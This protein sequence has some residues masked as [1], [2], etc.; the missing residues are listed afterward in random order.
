MFFI[1]TD[2]SHLTA[3]NTFG[4]LFWFK[5]SLSVERE[6]SS[7]FWVSCRVFMN[8][9]KR[10]MR[11]HFQG[12]VWTKTFGQINLLYND[13]IPLGK[14]CVWPDILIFSCLVN[15]VNQK[16]ARTRIHK[17]M[18][19]IVILGIV[20]VLPYSGQITQIHSK[21]NDKCC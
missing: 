7:L 16:I 8:K 1:L 11:G 13:V 12:F 18:N 20:V 6:N 19:M 3:I 10:F 21:V 5:Y 14:G 4:S 15:M 17:I 9:T 2:Q